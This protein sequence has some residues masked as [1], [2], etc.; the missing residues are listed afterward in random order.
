[1][2]APGSDLETVRLLL[3]RVLTRLAVHE[4]EEDDTRQI[5]FSLRSDLQVMP[6]EV[7]RACQTN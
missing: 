2:R 5:N 6:A 1:M 7:S 4:K 3:A